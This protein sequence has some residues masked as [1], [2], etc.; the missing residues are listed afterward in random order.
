VAPPIRPS[1][2]PR[3]AAGDFASRDDLIEKLEAYVIRHNENARPYRRT[4]EG[5]PLKAA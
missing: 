3:R 5:T 2:P 1:W 4:Y